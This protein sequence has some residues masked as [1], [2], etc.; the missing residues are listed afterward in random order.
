MYLNYMNLKVKP[1]KRVT[2]LSDLQ[3]LYIDL[4]IINLVALTMSLNNPS[5]RISQQAPPRILVNG[6]LMYF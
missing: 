2:N 3:F 6:K 5:E 1:S 4:I